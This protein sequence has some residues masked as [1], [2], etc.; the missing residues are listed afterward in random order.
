MP[1]PVDDVLTPEPVQQVVVLQRQRQRLVDV[2]PEPGI[3]GRRIPPPQHQIDAPLGQVLQ[4][5]VLLR[6]PHRVVGGDQ[7]GGGRDDQPLGGG[8][9]V[10]EKRR[11]RGGEERRVVVLPDREHVEPHFLGL[12]GD[13]HD[14]VDP[15]RL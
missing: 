11:R 4:H 15:F 1:L 14:R 8:G 9:H 5:R 3:D 10:G 7:R 6:D 12:L 2:L 13:L